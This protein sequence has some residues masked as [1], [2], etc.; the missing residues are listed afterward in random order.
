MKRILVLTSGGDAPGMNA[1]IRSVVRFATSKG[2]EVFG[3]LRGYR[4]LIDKSFIKLESKTVGNILQTGGTMLYTS[5][6][7]EFLTKKGQETAFKNLKELGVEGII[8]IGGDGS[9]AGAQVLEKAGFT[10]AC[11]P[12][13]IDNDLY[14]TD[15]TLGFDTAVNTL[16]NLINNIRDTGSSHERPSVI[17]VMG[18]WCGDIALNVGLAVG[19]EIIVLPEV[20]VEFE[21]VCRGVEFC[22]SNN[23]NSCLIVVNEK[24]F[25]AEDLS[26]RL[27]Q[28]LGIESR[29]VVVG[30]I[31]R[32]GS[33]TAN[34]RILAL[35]FGARAVDLVLGGKSGAVGIVNG[36]YIVCPLKDALHG[37]RKFNKEAYK[38]ASLVGGSVMAKK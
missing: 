38:L 20:K 22:K 26:A 15:Y 27:N 4:G 16:T 2:V 23:K 5:R 31:Q 30:H 9:F 8:V 7:E 29:P 34:D 14:Y 36:Q 33:P 6:C 25:S 10:V 24:T 11:V 3:A 35:N 17:E 18:A 1:C 19:A 13:T 28:K 37:K 21:D 32:G 12:G